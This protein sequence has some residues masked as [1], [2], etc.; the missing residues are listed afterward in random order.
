MKIRSLT[1]KTGEP[2]GHRTKLQRGA[3]V[4]RFW[5]EL[6]LRRQKHLATFPQGQI[7]SLERPSLTR[8]D[9]S[10]YRMQVLEKLYTM[11]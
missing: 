2:L 6:V 9:A 1:A 3:Y 8:N 10:Q 5:D 11:C 7:L 4:L